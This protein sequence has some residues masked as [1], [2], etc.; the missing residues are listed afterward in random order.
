LPAAKLKI[1]N[2]LKYMFFV[3]I[4]KKFLTINFIIKEGK[5]VLE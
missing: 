4:L 2:T 5:G 3:V 1:K